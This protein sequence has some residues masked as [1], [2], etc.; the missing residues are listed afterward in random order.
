MEVLTANFVVMSRNAKQLA[1]LVHQLKVCVLHLSDIARELDIFWDGDA[2]KEFNKAV[3]DDLM[4]VQGVILKV[5]VSV[6]RLQTAISEYQKTENIV[7]QM[8][9]GIRI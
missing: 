8:I 1:E 5:E 3:G 4:V 2:N 9:G 6:Q 7:N